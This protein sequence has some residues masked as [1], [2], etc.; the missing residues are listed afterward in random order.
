MNRTSA[1]KFT[2]LVP[3]FNEKEN[4]PELERRL[5]AFLP[6]CSVQPCCVLFVNDGSTDGGGEMVHEVCSRHEDFFYADL[7][8]NNGLSGAL[9]AGI[10]LCDSPLVGYI[11]AD[12]QTDPEDFNLLLA[13]SDRYPLVLGIRTERHDGFVK[14]ASSKIANSWRRMMTGDGIADTGCPLKVLWTPVAKEL[15]LFKGMHRFIPALVQMQGGECKEV[16]VH[17]HPRTAGKSKYHLAN[18][19]W[20]PFVDCFAFRWMR[21]RYT[22]AKTAETNL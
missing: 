9:K 20:G 14:R 18:R 22:P 8:V 17:H 1:Y 12:L 16:P 5:S 4:V 7:A 15:P 21:K 2:I 6:E 10:A 11:D 19:L 13:E 3:F